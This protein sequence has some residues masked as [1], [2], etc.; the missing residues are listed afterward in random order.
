MYVAAG[1]MQAACGALRD[2]VA[3]TESTALAKDFQA[4]QQDLGKI[5][6]SCEA[7]DE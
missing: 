3:N 7:T 5:P 2:G 4:F 1:R 6:L